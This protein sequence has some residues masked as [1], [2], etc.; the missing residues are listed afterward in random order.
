[1]TKLTASDAATGDSFGCSV[2]VAGDVAVVGAD[3]DDDVGS[4]SGSAYVFE[5]N[6]GGTNAWGQVAKLTAS[7]AAAGDWFGYS[8]SV[9]GDVALVGARRDGDAG[10]ASGSAYVFERDAG[11]TNAWGQVGK[12]VASDG[13]ASDYFGSSVSLDGDVAVVGAYQDDDVGSASGSAYIFERNAGG[14]NAWG[15][16]AKL[17]A[18]DGAADDYFGHSV[19]VAGHVVVVGA[20][21]DDDAGGGSG[22]AYVFEQWFPPPESLF[23]EISFQGSGDLVCAWTSAV[24]VDYT[25][26]F[27]DSLLVGAWSNL[28]GCVV[29]P[30]EDGVIVVTNAVDSIQEGYYRIKAVNS[31][32]R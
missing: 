4:A 2:A 25:V 27:R 15:Q 10:N 30:G 8:V 26:Q 7:D 11:G 19:S 29:L 18:S 31:P 6:A 24:P 14:T 3:G 32:L 22:S 16:V 28:A 9:A 17:T 1:M 12:I 23:L 20:Y 5:R 13:T 21:G